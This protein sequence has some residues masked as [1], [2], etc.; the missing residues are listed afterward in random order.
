MLISHVTGYNVK[1]KSAG[2]HAFHFQ[3][4]STVNVNLAMN[5]QPQNQSYNLSRA[6]VPNFK[7]H[8]IPELN[9]PGINLAPWVR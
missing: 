2:N 9:Q 6:M 8:T 3:F 4:I 5:T 1:R 7:F